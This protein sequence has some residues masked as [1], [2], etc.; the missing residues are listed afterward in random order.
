MK[1]LWAGVFIVCAVLFSEWVADTLYLL[2]F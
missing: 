1:P 2:L